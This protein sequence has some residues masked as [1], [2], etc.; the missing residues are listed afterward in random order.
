IP[1]T[2]LNAL[3]GRPLPIY[4]DGSNVREWLFV[5]DHARALVLIAERGVVGEYY[6][7]G[8]ASEISNIALVR[9]I[10][11]LLDELKPDARFVS[12]ERL[13]SHVG[14]RPG[15]DFRY[16]LDASKLKRELGWSPRQ[17]FKAGLRTTVEWYL[18][19]PQWW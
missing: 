11:T 14:D 3:E 9:E 18:A 4:G 12:R 19:N 17:R 16:A 13:I 15:H 5:E 7:V 6:D 10:C 8:G 2:I 1:L